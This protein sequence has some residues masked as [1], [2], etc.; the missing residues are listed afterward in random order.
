[1]AAVRAGDVL[2]DIYVAQ[3]R[4]WGEALAVE[5]RRLRRQSE[6]GT[7]ETVWVTPAPANPLG[8]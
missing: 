6:T 5:V 4:Q 3:A 7:V 2:P 1:M 8:N